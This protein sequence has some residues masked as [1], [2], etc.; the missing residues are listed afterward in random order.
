MGVCALQAREMS[1][2]NYFGN[3]ILGLTALGKVSVAPAAL[4]SL[5]IHHCCFT[6]LAVLQPARK[7]G[8]PCY[9]NR[10]GSQG[11]Q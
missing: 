6:H 7:E 3:D 5:T 10:P 4:V 2:E 9:A 1:F 11:A 8:M